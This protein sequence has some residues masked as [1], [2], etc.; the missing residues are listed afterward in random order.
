[1]RELRNSS[2]DGMTGGGV[3]QTDGQRGSSKSW[4]YITSYT[5]IE[6]VSSFYKK[7]KYRLAYRL[8]YSL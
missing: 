4:I 6:A 3:T 8:P 5:L 7:K 2:T 1:M